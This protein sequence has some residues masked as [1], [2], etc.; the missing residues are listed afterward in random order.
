MP[1]N[2][3]NTYGDYLSGVDTEESAPTCPQLVKNILKPEDMRLVGIGFFIF[4]IAIGLYLIKVRGML[5]LLIGFLGI[6]GG[7][8]YT[9]GIAYKYKGLGVFSIYSYGPHDGM[10]CYFVQTGVSSWLRYG[11]PYR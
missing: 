2:L 10:G 9:L 3:I 4:T 6:I 5:L 8:G 1:V 7:Y 11:L